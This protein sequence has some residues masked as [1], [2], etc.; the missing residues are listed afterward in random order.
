MVI[1]TLP[2]ASASLVRQPV[3]RTMVQ[4]TPGTV[5]ARRVRQQP[6]EPLDFL[7]QLAQTP[8]TRH[9]ETALL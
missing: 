2:C 3:Q 4:S 7:L 8:D 1:V 9:L 6:R 5:Q